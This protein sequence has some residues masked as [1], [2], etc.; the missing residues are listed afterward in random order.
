MYRIILYCIN[1]EYF[2][3]VEG[4]KEMKF[5]W[6]DLAY[7]QFMLIEFGKINNS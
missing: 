4:T 5:T 6:N 7:K 1:M 3:Y 2:W